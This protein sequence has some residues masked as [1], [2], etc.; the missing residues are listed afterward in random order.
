[1]KRSK[2]LTIALMGA[3]A[4]ALTACDDPQE[5]AVFE[6]VEQCTRQDGFDRETCESTFR[7]A[8]AA[9]VSVSPKYTDAADCEAD[10]GEGQCQTAPMRTTSGGSVFMPMMMGYMIGNMMA[11]GSRVATQ[12]LYRAGNDASAFRTADNQKVATRT[13]LNT[14][15]AAAAK[16]PS[17]KTATVAR[18]GFGAGA[19]RI[20][21]G[22]S[23]FGG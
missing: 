21:G 11:G 19:G 12:P 17:V 20:G 16:A 5:A 13:G 8:Q 23:G 2:T 9:H 22:F 18:G 10:F 6:S 14:V 15:P 7:E 1:M 3:T 4:L